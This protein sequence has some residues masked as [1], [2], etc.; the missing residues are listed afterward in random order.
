[1]SWFKKFKHGLSK[2]GHG[3]VKGAGSVVKTG[4]KAGKSVVKS[5]KK[6]FKSID[7]RIQGLNPINFLQ[8]NIMLIAGVLIVGLVVL[9]K[10]LDSGAA[11]EVA[12]RAP[13]P[14]PAAQAV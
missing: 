7:K 2:L 10:V 8:K 6:V 14:L 3:I 4:I 11:R 9:P 5:S 12:R 13:L 1:M